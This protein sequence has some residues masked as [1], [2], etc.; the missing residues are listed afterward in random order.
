MEKRDLEIKTGNKSLVVVGFIL[1]FG[2]F[3]SLVGW[4]F[5]SKIDTVV[6]AQGKVILDNYKKPVEYK[7]WAVVRQVMVKEGDFVKAGQV[8][9]EVD[10]LEESAMKN[11]SEYDFYSLL[12]R[13]DRLMAEKDFSPRV[14]YSSQLMS[15][16]NKRLL[17]EVIAYQNQL[18][19][20]RR[21]R[22]DN[23]LQIIDDRINQSRQRIDDITK[24]KQIK[25]D[26]LSIYRQSIQEERELLAKGLSTKDRVLNLEEKINSLT[27]DIKELEAQLQQERLKIEENL[28]QKDLAIKDY[29]TQ[30][31]NEL[32]EV[33]RS[34]NDSYQ[35]MDMY[36]TK[37]ERSYIKADIDGQVM[38]LKVFYPQ[39][40]IKPGDVIMYVVPTGKNI[41]VDGM[42]LPNDRDK[43]KPGM[44]VEINF[45]SFISL[46]A[47]KIKGKLVFISD[48]TVYEEAIKTEI[49]RVKAEITPEGMRTIK[50]NSFEIVAGMPAV[51]FIKVEKVSPFEYILQP[52]YQMVKSSFKSN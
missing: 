24:I 19:N 49:Y 48:D 4:G 47:R 50:E 17:Q 30:A 7:E 43:V 52:V 6:I 41:V 25:T 51:M 40:V 14:S 1:V 10:R 26:Q 32:Q 22:L 3:G 39:Q 23:Q 42:L 8:L 16:P 44:E 33:F 15:A 45:P 2:I 35:K 37:V 38:G 46:S 11:I 34:L 28:K 21:Q 31:A 20:E 27:A 9:V 13:R 18:F 29:T 36:N 12:A 5:L